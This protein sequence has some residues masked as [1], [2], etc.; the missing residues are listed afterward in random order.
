MKYLLLIIFSILVYNLS[1]AQNCNP[2]M[3]CQMPTEQIIELQSFDKDSK[4]AEKAEYI[5]EELYLR[6]DLFYIAIENKNY[7]NI[8]IQ[9]DAIDE[10]IN[11]AQILK[12]NYDMFCDDIN[13]I[14]IIKQQ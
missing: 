2:Q 13:N 5:L 4:D 8:Q 3:I 1:I 9:I 14:E 11:S 6:F 12:M 7:T 10:A